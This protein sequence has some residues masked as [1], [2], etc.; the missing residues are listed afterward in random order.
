MPRVQ[1]RSQ[2]FRGDV[3]YGSGTLISLL[4]R[5]MNNWNGGINLDGTV[6]PITVRALW[7]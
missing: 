2:P 3:I 7:P 1:R 5:A 4:P 6:W